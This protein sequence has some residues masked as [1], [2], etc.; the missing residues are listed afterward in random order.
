[1]KKNFKRTL[2]KVMAVALTVSMVGVA[3]TDA[4]AAKKIKLSS[5]SI[6][7][8]KGATKKVTIKNVKAKKVKKLTVKS[9]DKKIATVKKAGKTAIKVTGK[10][11]G[12]STKVTVKVKVGKKTTKLTL[13]VKVTKAK[14]VVPTAAPTTA[15]TAVPS[16]SASAAPAASASTTPSAKP[17]ATP[18]ASASA[19]PSATPVA[20]EPVQ[21][22]PPTTEAKQLPEV[23]LRR[24]NVPA[25]V[26]KGSYCTALFNTDDT[27]SFSSKPWKAAGNI[28]NNGIIWYIDSAKKGQVDLS[29][30]SEVALTIKTDAEV[31][32]MTWGGSADA[33]DFWS[34]SDVWGST[35]SVVE[36]EDG[37][38]TIT[39][40]ITTAFGSENK[41]KK[42]VAIGF[43]LKSE[44]ATEKDV[45][46]E[47]TATVYGIKFIKNGSAQPETPDPETPGPETPKTDTA[48][49]ET[50]DQPQPSTS[51]AELSDLAVD[52]T[53][54]SVVEVKSYGKSPAF[55][56]ENGI[57]TLTSYGEYTGGRMAVKIDIP[58]G[59]SLSDYYGI[60][61]D[62]VNTGEEITTTNNKRFVVEVK[63]NEADSLSRTTI[64]DGNS[65]NINILTSDFV[66]TE[67]K[68]FA[69]NDEKTIVGAFS[70]LD[71]VTYDLTGTQTLLIGPGQEISGGY[72]IKNVKLL[73]KNPSK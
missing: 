17:S 15:P 44:S 18:T 56:V 43:T 24:D 19:T 62:V 21:P 9:A 10:K 71:T 68:A 36:N 63:G 60:S 11:A 54:D 51:P 12:K 57:A 69:V 49:T 1:M 52:L 67:D 35:K 70:N 46:E 37:S 32:L 34:K 40:D 39:Y 58:E 30:Y 50:P 6:S 23:N 22:E 16:A 2:A 64:Q 61:F 33:E 41:V 42:A 31:K 28:Y 25:W 14:K 8:A 45:F 5:K 4:D 20:T 47:K 26:L 66:A 3:S 65:K 59:H 48:S 73:A 13:K 38:K 27:V 53:T 72:A 55:S 7:V 29:A